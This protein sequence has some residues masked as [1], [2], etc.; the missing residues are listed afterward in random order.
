MN[1]EIGTEAAQFPE[2][3]YINGIFDAVWIYFECLAMPACLGW[4]GSDLLVGDANVQKHFVHVRP[5]SNDLHRV[6]TL[7]DPAEVKRKDITSFLLC[8]L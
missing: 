6:R 2:K 1:V 8:L 4:P 3:E 7:D 5:V